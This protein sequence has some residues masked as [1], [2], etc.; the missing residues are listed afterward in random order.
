MPLGYI[1]REYSWSLKLTD[2]LSGVSN[3]LLNP[4]NEFFIST[5]T[6]FIPKKL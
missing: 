5:I 1:Q 6:F 2:P 4:L 3:M